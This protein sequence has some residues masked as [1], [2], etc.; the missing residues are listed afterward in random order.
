M[1]NFN[2]QQINDGG[3]TDIMGFLLE[4]SCGGDIFYVFVPEWAGQDAPLHLHYQCAQCEQSYCHAGIC[5][6]PQRQQETSE[7]PQGML[8][9]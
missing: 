3:G 2:L 5:Q 7:A 1:L 4:C 8:Q 6:I 9:G